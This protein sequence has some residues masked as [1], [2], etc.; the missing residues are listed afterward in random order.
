MRFTLYFFISILFFSSCNN[1]TNNTSGTNVAVSN[2]KKANDT[3]K[4]DSPSGIGEIA[5]QWNGLSGISKITR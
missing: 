5:S 4:F 2:A 3:P 1:I